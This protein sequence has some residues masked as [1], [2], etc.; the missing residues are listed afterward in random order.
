M[1]SPGNRHCANCIGALSFP[2][3][4]NTNAGILSHSESDFEV[5]GPQRRY[6]ASTGEVLA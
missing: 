1:A 3:A 2:I 5:F 4:R 6:T